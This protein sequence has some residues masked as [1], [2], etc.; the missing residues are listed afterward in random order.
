MSKLKP[1]LAALAALFALLLASRAEAS[2]FRYGN[3]TYTVPDPVNAPLTVRFD[4][5]VAWREDYPFIDS[6]TL[7]FG[8]GQSNPPNAGATIGTGT[9]AAGLEYLVQRYTTTHKY[10]SPGVYT[11]W[12]TSCCRTSNLINAGDDSFRVEARVDVTGN[13]KKG[14]PVSA[15]PAIIQ[16][17]TGGVRTIQIP[18]VDPNGLPVSCRFG[19]QAESMILGPHPPTV[20]ATGAVATI[21]PSVSPPGCVITW[22]TTGGLA[23]QQYAMQVAIDRKSVV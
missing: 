20:P 6:T 22:N 21:A 19:N 15:V 16:L 3:I 12:F 14:N 4:V 17:Q 8:D 18:A 2:H 9:D 11:V 10:A 5:T 7:N 13:G 1:F 23:G